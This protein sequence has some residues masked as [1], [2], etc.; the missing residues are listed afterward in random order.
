[1]KKYI[2]VAKWEYLEKVKTKAFLIS[3]FLTPVL[4]IFFNVLP[5]LL[6]EKSEEKDLNYI[7][8]DKTDSFSY[9]FSDSI[10]NKYLKKDNSK[11][12][13]IKIEKYSVLDSA[14]QNEILKTKII[15]GEIDGFVIIDKKSDNNFEIKFYGENIGSFE[16]PSRFKNTLNEI[17]FAQNLKNEN[18]P[19][20][21]I[22]SLKPK[23]EFTNYKI[24]EKGDSTKSDF[25]TTFFTSYVFIILFMIL[26]LSTGQ[27]LIRSV[28]EEKSNKLIEVLLSS[29]SSKDLLVGKIL[30]LSALGFTSILVWILFGIFAA[31]FV[32][33]YSFSLGIISVLL[34]LFYFI[35]G[36]IFFSSIFV[37]FGST[38]TTEQ[39]AQQMTGYVTMFMV[40]P[41]A[42][43]VPMMQNPD[44][45][46]VK[47]LSFI[48]IF[49]PL[50]MMMR[51]SI[52][53]PEVW[54][55]IS[56]L[57]ILIS[58]AYGMMIAGSKIFRIG[59]LISGKRPKLKEI[60]KWIK[61]K[62]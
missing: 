17:I 56:T 43:I 2:A 7:L 38:C 40:L 4:I 23:I 53:M 31:L 55:I 41:I 58:S 51:I 30:G 20:K 13:N 14:R 37:A 6:I 9:S 59:I 12:Y 60:I 5:T 50:F 62:D 21:K 54:E 11:L 61:I 27:M 18:L 46:I 39:E 28:V 26:T 25:L 8:I 49:T 35:F 22:E 24:N 44:Q 10:E 29:C 32:S 3:L 34:I 48:P 36:Y 1:M 19:Y 33:S 15:D 42:F 47:I 52:K 57:I 16:N 45:Q